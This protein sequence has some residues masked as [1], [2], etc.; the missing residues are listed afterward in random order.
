MCVKMLVQ[1]KFHQDKPTFSHS[2]LL[3]ALLHL[4]SCRYTSPPCRKADCHCQF[5]FTIKKKNNYFTLVMVYILE[6]FFFFK[7]EHWHIA[8]LF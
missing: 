2:P 7:L 1:I 6:L 8:S 4:A 3:P 5:L